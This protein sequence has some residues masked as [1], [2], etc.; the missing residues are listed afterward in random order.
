MPG[1]A[2]RVFRVKR[3][4]NGEKRGFSVGN[5]VG[6]GVA[7]AAVEASRRPSNKMFATATIQN[8][9]KDMTC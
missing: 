1:E 9:R 3:V 7:M 2:W 8:G 5:D 6:T 4:R